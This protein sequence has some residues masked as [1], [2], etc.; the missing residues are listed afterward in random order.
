MASEVRRDSGAPVRRRP[1]RIL[2]IINVLTL[3]AFF[4]VVTAVGLFVATRQQEGNVERVGELDGVLADSQGPFSNYLLVGSDTREGADP[5]SPDYGGIG[6]TSETGGRRSD[7]VM[8]LH[9]DNQR[10]NASIMSIPRD[11]WVDVPGF[12]NDRINTA[13]T[14]GADVLVDTVQT[15]LGVPINHYIEVDFNSFKNIVGALGGVD[16]CFEYPTR[17][18]HT[19]LYVPEPGCFTL[20]ALQSLAYARSRYFETFRDGAWVVDGR[21]DLGRVVRQQEFLQAAIT[22]AV[23]E[24][25]SNPLRTSQLLDAAVASVK[26]DPGTNLVES[27]DY[28]RSL[29]SGGV[30]RYS[31]PVVPEMVGDKD[32]LV[33]GADAPAVLAYF[34]GLGEPPVPNG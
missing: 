20:D 12:G 32:V 14:H 1:R 4:T 24:T 29:V 18:V 10:G 25:T 19:G 28:L 9:V 22:K 8:I 15:S 7:T 26:V 11:L 16:V 2:P 13:Y 34:A 33:L 17:D 27:G 5:N 3:A 23:A 30:A 6:D 21:S 31:L